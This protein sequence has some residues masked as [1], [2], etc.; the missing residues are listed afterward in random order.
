M[1]D[2]EYSTST[3]KVTPT[4]IQASHLQRQAQRVA[5]TPQN[6]AMLLW[7]DFLV[8]RA[9]AQKLTHR[10]QEIERLMME[11]IG[12]PVINVPLADGDHVSTIDSKDVQELLGGELSGANLSEKKEVSLEAHQ[13]RWCAADAELGYSEALRAEAEALRQLCGLAE[14]LWATPATSITG[15][16]AKLDALLSEGAP[17]PACQDFPWPQLR[18]IRADLENLHVVPSPASCR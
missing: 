17:S 2:S 16:I 8:A 18:A 10:Q 5:L 12:F 14:R 4:A 13:A 1:T 15:V 7:C 11:R 6:S 3:N 9:S